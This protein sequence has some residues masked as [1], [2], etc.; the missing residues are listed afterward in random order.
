[1][2][3]AILKGYKNNI[4]TILLANELTE[5]YN[6]KMFHNDRYNKINELKNILDRFET[7]LRI[8]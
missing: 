8:I 1:M 3:I 2:K 7:E 6:I 5:N 4:A